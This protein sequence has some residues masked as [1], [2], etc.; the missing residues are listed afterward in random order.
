MPPW[1]CP[2]TGLRAEADDE[3]KRQLPRHR[4]RDCAAMHPELAQLVESSQP[5][6]IRLGIPLWQRRRGRLSGRFSL[7]ALLPDELRDPDVEVHGT[8]TFDAIKDLLRRRPG[9]LSFKATSEGRS[10]LCQGRIERLLVSDPIDAAAAFDLVSVYGRDDSLREEPRQGG[11]RPRP[12]P[13]STLGTQGWRRSPRAQRRARIQ[14]AWCPPPRPLPRGVNPRSSRISLGR[15]RPQELPRRYNEVCGSLDRA[16]H[17]LA[18]NPD[19]PN[20]VGGRRWPAERPGPGAGARKEGDPRG[21]P[22]LG[23]GRVRMATRGQRRLSR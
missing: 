9:N 22:D 12:V 18:T 19:A 7:G 23:A 13:A 21:G 5:A 20:I 10:R 4:G 11:G 15:M 17:H 2:R 8:P 14:P 6:Q 16:R 1:P 3:A